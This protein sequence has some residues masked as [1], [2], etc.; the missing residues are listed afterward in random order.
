MR[1]GPILLRMAGLAVRH[2][3]LVAPLIGA[4]WRFRARDWYRRWPFV[5][6]PP[7]KYV[8]W[9]LH[10]AYGDENRAPE[11]T[12]LARYLRWTSRMRDR[13]KE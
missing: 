9:R 7:A 13:R 8:E 11:A 3:G 6:L 4:A 12:E 10:T 1:Y 5:P 2:P